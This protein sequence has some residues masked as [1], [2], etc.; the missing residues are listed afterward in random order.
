MSLFAETPIKQKER[1][2]APGG[3]RHLSTSWSIENSLQDLIHSAPQRPWHQVIFKTESLL[4]RVA[5]ANG[6]ALKIPPKK[7]IHCLYKWL[8]NFQ[9]GKRDWKTQDLGVQSQVSPRTWI[10]PRLLIDWLIDSS[11]LNNTCI[12]VPQQNTWRGIRQ[13][14]PQKTGILPL[15]VTTCF[16]LE[17]SVYPQVPGRVQTHLLMPLLHFT[18]KFHHQ[19]LGPLVS[20]L[21]GLTVPYPVSAAVT[22]ATKKQ[23][24]FSL[25]SWSNVL[26]FFSTGII[27]VQNLIPQSY[28][29]I[30]WDM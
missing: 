21:H 8:P 3:R 13:I 25:R 29:R 30:L 26:F 7:Y 16:F 10:Q 27:I 28:S 14:P 2:A 6:H 17:R 18:L 12:T 11:K 24:Y 23:K 9:K 15:L 19:F 22:C 20:G 4:F 1:W 5:I